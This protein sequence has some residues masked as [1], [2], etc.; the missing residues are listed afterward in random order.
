LG[1]FK[2]PVTAAETGGDTA[3]LDAIMADIAGGAIVGLATGGPA[4]GNTPYVVGEVGPE[5]FVPKTDGYVIPNHALGLNRAGGGPVKAGGAS[6]FSQSDFAS[7]LLKGLGVSSP[8]QQAIQDIIMWEGKEGGNWIN[9]AKYNPLNT[10]YQLNGSVNF[11][12]G[13]AGGG[14]QAYTSWDQGVAATVNTLTGLNAKSRGYTAIVDALKKGGVSSADFLKLMQASN[15]D[16]GHYGGGT[17]SSGTGG[18]AT[19]TAATQTSSGAI[20]NLSSL[21]ASTLGGTVAT[22]AAPTNNQTNYN[23]GGVNITIQADKNPQATA[24]AV[25]KALKDTSTATA[26]GNG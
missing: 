2:N 1:I 5:L 22:P 23:Y 19:P 9:S 12:T 6:G 11:D 16:K 20:S 4:Q 15:W 10:S 7:A 17:S 18:V 24:A 21:I 3:F 25:K 13:K 14:V 8:A 26:V